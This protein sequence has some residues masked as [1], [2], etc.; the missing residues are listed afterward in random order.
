MKRVRAGLADNS[1]DQ[2]VKILNLLAR[3]CFC[4]AS[5]SA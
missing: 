5:T 3:G 4:T 1:P 2:L